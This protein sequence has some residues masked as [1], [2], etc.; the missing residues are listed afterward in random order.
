MPTQAA[1]PVAN[2]AA[3]ITL[4]AHAELTGVIW[5]YDATPTGGNLLIQDGGSTICSFDITVAGPGFMDSPYPLFGNAAM[6]LTL[7]A[8]GSGVKGKL[9]TKI[10]YFSN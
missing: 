3:V 6:T 10:Y 2:T 8:G 7:A 4:P 1:T 5:S 9:A